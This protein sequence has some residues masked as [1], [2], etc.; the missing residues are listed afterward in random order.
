MIN[1]A[2]DNL[3]ET[4]CAELRRGLSRLSFIGMGMSSEMDKA[5]ADLRK[6]IKKRATN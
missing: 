5:L 2:N 1:E 6:G 3:L 4:E